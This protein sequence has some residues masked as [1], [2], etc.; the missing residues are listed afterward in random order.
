VHF[1][2][3]G[4]VDGSPFHTRSLLAPGESVDAVHLRY[5]AALEE[6]LTVSWRR[7]GRDLRPRRVSHLTLPRKFIADLPLAEP[8]RVEAAARRVIE[9]VATEGLEL[10]LNTAG[11]DK[12]SC[13]EIYLPETLLA[14]ALAL[15]IPL[16]FGSDAHK[17]AD[18]GRHHDLALQLLNPSPPPAT[19]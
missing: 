10:D 19:Q 5:Y 6:A 11:L 3:D 2:G 16:V 17:S 8:E 9:R 14:Y 15:G 7:G 1:L 12:P 18:V 13:G 4:I